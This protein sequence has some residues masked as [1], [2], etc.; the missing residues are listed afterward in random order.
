MMPDKKRSYSNVTPLKRKLESERRRLY[1][2]IFEQHHG[3]L[4]AFI[5]KM[6]VTTEEAKDIAQ[7]VFYRVL[8]QNEPEKLEHAPRAYLN[9]IAM[10]LMRDK[11]RKEHAAKREH[12]ANQVSLTDL[13]ENEIVSNVR[14]PEVQVK[15]L[16]CLELLKKALKEL[17]PN[18]RR[19]FMLHRF[20]H[21]SCNEIS[22]DLGVPLR[23]VERYLSQAIAYCQERVGEAYE[24]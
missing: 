11:I 8:R 17:P 14:K 2:T 18:Q 19:V 10:N 6:S 24:K 12:A 5:R 1:E 21:L 15:W 13:S 22:Q 7:D 9:Q 4:L 3:A 16:E 20:N 23:T